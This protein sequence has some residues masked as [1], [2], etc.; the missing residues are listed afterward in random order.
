MDRMLFIA[1]SGAK[2][3]SLAQ[4]NNANNL[5][6]ANTDGFKKD[7]NQFRA[8][9]VEGPGWNSRAYALNERVATDFSPGAVRVTGRS[10]DIMTKDNG[11]FK[12]LAPDGTEA[13]V[14]TASL[15][16]NAVGELVDSR[17]NPILNIGGAPIS[18]PEHKAIEIA[19][20]GTVSV[21]PSDS[22]DNFMVDIDQIQMVKPDLRQLTKG[23]DGYIRSEEANLEPANVVLLSG[24]IE[25]SNVNTVRALTTM[26]EL[27]RQFELQ[28][29]M[30]NVAKDH[31][32]KTD[33]L[34]RLS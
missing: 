1:M 3:V 28:I 21:I 2:E 24:A 31:A 18:L 29:K 4:A 15:R 30:M 10:L 13:L 6:N 8:Q 7:F 23:L 27:S 34:V 32:Q 22:V 5:A 17:N 14:R 19:S 20:D 9:H 11:F 33:S 26:I 16:V 12:I 25:T